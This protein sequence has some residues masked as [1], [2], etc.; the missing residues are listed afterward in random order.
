M[1]I[2]V[3][4]FAHSYST[5]PYTYSVP[6]LWC[7]SIILGCLVEIPFGKKE[8]FGIVVD[9][10]DSDV[11]V[12]DIRTIRPII[13][14][15]AS[16]E[17]LSH[18]QRMMILHLAGRFFLS[19][20]RVLNLFLPTPLMNRLDRKNYILYRENLSERNVSLQPIRS[21]HYF[22]DHAFGLSDFEKLL[23]PWTVMVV[24]DDFFLYTF[25]EKLSINTGTLPAEATPVRKAWFWMNTYEGKEKIIVWTRRLLYYNLASYERVYFIED[26]FGDEDY[27]YPIRIRNRDVLRIF[28]DTTSLDVTIITSSP[29]LDTFAYFRDFTIITQ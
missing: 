14:V 1:Y 4:P 15:V 19:L 25:T 2:A 24:P 18:E 7:E 22:R 21:I 28:A 23:L 5:E 12:W 29:T 10:T 20:D 11:N 9:C 27:Q 17:L 8:D 3:I 13:R 16:V 6:E 26:A